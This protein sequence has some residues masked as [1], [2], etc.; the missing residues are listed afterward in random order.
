MPVTQP[1]S[2]AP[3]LAQKV[4]KLQKWDPE[5]LTKMLFESS[6]LG[7]VAAEGFIVADAGDPPL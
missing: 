7:E 2:K 3:T 4:L 5:T 1:G 6:D